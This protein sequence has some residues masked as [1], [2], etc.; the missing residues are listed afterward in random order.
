MPGTM[1]RADLMADLKASLH[2]AAEV[3]T[4]ENDADF[5]RL[6]DVAVLDFAR[7]RPR[8]LVGSLTLEAGQPDYT[9]AADFHFFKADLWADPNRMGRPWEKSWT[10]RLPSVVPATVDGVR[11]LVFQPAP[12]AQQIAV[13]GSTFRYYYFARHEIGETDAETT[14]QSADR[15]LLILRAQAE[16]MREMAMRN[17]AKPMQMRDGISSAPRNGTPSHLYSVLMD[18]FN[19]A[20]A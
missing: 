9:P 18:E 1:A 12:S 15:G 7:L 6:L 4:A 17:I 3:F 16:A 13:L 2:D 11:K 10:G 20:V 5:S 14:I 8:T 19:R